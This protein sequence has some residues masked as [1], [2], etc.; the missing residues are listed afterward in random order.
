MTRGLHVRLINPRGMFSILRS[1]LVGCFEADKM[2]CVPVF[3]W[4]GSV[5][6]NENPNLWP[7]FFESTSVDTIHDT[8]KLGAH[9][10]IPN[11][12]SWHHIRMK[13]CAHIKNIRPLADIMLAVNV[14][15]P[16]SLHYRALDK[17]RECTIHPILTY[18]E[19]TRKLCENTGLRSVFVASDAQ[20]CVDEA[21][22][23]LQRHGIVVTSYKHKRAPFRN[24]PGLHLS[25]TTTTTERLQNAKEAII[26]AWTLSRSDYL[27]SNISN[28]SYWSTYLNGSQTHILIR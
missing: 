21:T 19:T 11:N 5:Y 23:Y 7:S 6:D 26:D 28:L 3:T 13:A 24:G 9:P 2:G 14:I 22:A 25:T 12:D 27:I 1:A 10:G 15:C 18:L 16:I 4:E 20:D 17:K 8:I